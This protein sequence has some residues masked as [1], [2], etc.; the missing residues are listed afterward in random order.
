MF[1]LGKPITVTTQPFLTNDDCSLFSST[2][3]N[4]RTIILG[5]CCFLDF[6]LKQNDFP[7]SF[8][9][10][11]K[12]LNLCCS[13]CHEN[14]MGKS[15]LQVLFTSY[16]FY[17]AYSQRASLILCCVLPCVH[18]HAVKLEYGI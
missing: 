2:V 1:L 11:M 7:T 4:Q 16:I 15:H 10:E 18:H 12:P 5:N 17:L 9:P 13:I 14:W 6:L 8:R 3:W